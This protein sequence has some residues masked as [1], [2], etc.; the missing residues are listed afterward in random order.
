M[1]SADYPD[2]D[3][4]AHLHTTGQT[5][6]LRD[7]LMALL[8][9]PDAA[10]H[11]RALDT[12]QVLTAIFPELEPARDCDQPIVH[13]LPVL[14]HSLEAVAVIDWLLGQLYGWP[15][16]LPVAAQLFPQIHYRSAYA[17]QLRDHFRTTVGSY[18]RTAL[19]RLAALLH[20]NAKPQTKRPKPGGGVSFHDHQTIGGHIAAHMLT[21]LGF[22]EAETSYVWL[23]VREHMRPGQLYAL[24][25][26]TERAVRR[27]FNDL[28]TDAPDVLLHLLADHMATRGPMLK[29]SAWLAQAKWV[30]DMLAIQW[31]EH[32]QTPRPLVTGNDVMKALGIGPGPLV[33]RLLQQVREAHGSGVVTT[34]E[35]A[36]TLARQLWEAERR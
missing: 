18:P 29:P 13:F 31:G 24:H 33:G 9:Q 25:E 1:S 14:G 32:T 15:A 28:S 35:A 3:T 2:P 30:D 4:I 8:G 6:A 23:V 27:L 36:L 16:A 10:T 11:L 20:D 26:I 22:G 21:R 7:A 17:R 19:L 5:A 34:P 12:R